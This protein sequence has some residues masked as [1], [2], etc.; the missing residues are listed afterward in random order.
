MQ[1]V[2]SRQR[3]QSHFRN[4]MAWQRAACRRGK[5]ECVEN[6]VMP[7]SL[8]GVDHAGCDKYGRRNPILLKDWKCVLVVVAITIIKRYSHCPLGQLA[9]PAAFYQFE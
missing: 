1:V 2:A 4:A 3:L 9:A 8:A 5:A 7:E 6:S